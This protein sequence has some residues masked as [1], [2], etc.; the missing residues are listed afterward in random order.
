MTSSCG[1]M[2]GASPWPSI[3]RQGM[4]RSRSA[5]SEPSRAC[6]PSEITS[7]SLNASSEGI[8]LL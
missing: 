3:V 6:S 8:S 7:S 5:V 4:N 2:S 1:I